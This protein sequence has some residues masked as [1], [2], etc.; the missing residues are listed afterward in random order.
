MIAL[1][2]AEVLRLR[3]RRAVWFLAILMVALIV[4]VLVGYWFGTR[5][6]TPAQEAEFQANYQYAVDDWNKHGAEEI[7]DCKKGEAEERKTNPGVDYHCDEIG[8]PKPEN[9]DYTS[10]TSYEQMP[11]LLMGLGAVAA[12]F[13]VL[14][15]ATYVGADHAA[16][17]ISTQLLFAPT[18][19]K[20][21]V[22]K[23]TAIG[24]AA[25]G[26]AVVSVGLGGLGA[27][28]VMKDHP[29]APANADGPV[30]PLVRVGLWAV[31]M[32]VVVTLVAFSVSWWFGHTVA[33]VGLLAGVVIGETVLAGVRQSLTPWLPGRNLGAIVTGKWDYYVQ[34]CHSI[35]GDYECTEVD[36]SIFRGHGLVMWGIVLLVTAV[37]SVLWFSRRD[38]N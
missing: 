4:T 3:K 14:A 13:L 26:A 36:L 28:A 1:I 32:V 30:L 5:P 27:W 29:K 20:V 38:V 11:L 24:S 23:A 37:S 18:R 10:R 12:G 22:A 16:G 9:Y 25:V 19:W 6:P 8:P 34:S 35:P 21:W 31:L 2:R 7:A 15:S 17:T 33:T